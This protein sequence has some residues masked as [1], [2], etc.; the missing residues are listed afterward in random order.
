MT[1]N[2]TKL[3]KRVFNAVNESKQPLRPIDLQNILN[4]KIRSI[5]Y[6]VSVLEDRDLVVRSPDLADIRTFYVSPNRTHGETI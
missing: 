5:R 1:K 4:L 2:M 6:A 3:L